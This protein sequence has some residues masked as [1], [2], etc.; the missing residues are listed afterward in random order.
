MHKK[1][2]NCLDITSLDLNC[3]NW[4]I[5][6][7]SASTY[8][9]KQIENFKINYEWLLKVW[10]NPYEDMKITKHKIVFL[11]KMILKPFS[12]IIL[13]STLNHLGIPVLIQ[14][15]WILQFRIFTLYTSFGVYLAFLEHWF[16]RRR[17][18][19]THPIFTVSRLS[20]FKNG[21]R[22]LHQSP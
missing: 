19:K 2:Y 12:S 3:S 14:G 21:F 17:F 8:Q 9:I 15:S 1:W 7:S 6:I 20:P 5:S 22:P 10:E 18:L 13:Y 4:P 16:L 11:E